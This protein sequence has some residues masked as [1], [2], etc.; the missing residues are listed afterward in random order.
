MAS[1]SPPAY[2]QRG[3]PATSPQQ[4]LPTI[5]ESHEEALAA[6]QPAG[7]CCA[8]PA[9]AA[10]A[11]GGQL[12]P[13]ATGAAAAGIDGDVEEQKRQRQ[14]AAAAA[15]GPPPR[16]RR[17]DA[18]AAGGGPLAGQEYRLALPLPCS[19]PAAVLSLAGPQAACL[20]PQVH[21]AWAVVPYTP[22]GAALLPVGSS[23][24]LEQ[25]LNGAVSRDCVT[26]WRFGAADAEQGGMQVGAANGA[27]RH[28]SCYACGGLRPRRGP[29]SSSSFIASY[30]ALSNIPHSLSLPLQRRRHA[31]KHAPSIPLAAGGKPTQQ[32][33]P[34]SATH[35]WLHACQ[36]LL[37]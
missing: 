2:P 32:G 25:P 34:N 15:A 18:E 5:P 24:P 17:V 3:Q 9:A 31:L 29:G 37:P 22:P 28:L 33:R 10:W 16:R 35:A 27:L 20:Q 7:P 21:A 26:Q 11:S 1:S 30:T 23:P 12:W 8:W 13:A 6:E 36:A 19:I 4:T 14:E